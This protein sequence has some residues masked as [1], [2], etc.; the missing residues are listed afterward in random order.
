VAHF[1]LF[2]FL[3]VYIDE[4]ML[5]HVM[6]C[7]V[8]SCHV[9]SCHVTLCYVMSCHVML[10]HIAKPKLQNLKSILCTQ[11]FSFLI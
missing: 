11:Y 9:M 5:C 3:W 2:D 10:C 1:C 4:I 7:Y 8:M 6:L